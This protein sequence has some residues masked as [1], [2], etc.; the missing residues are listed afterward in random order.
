MTRRCRAEVE[1]GDLDGRIVV[2][3][4]ETGAIDLAHAVG[5]SDGFATE[6]LEAVEVAYPKNEEE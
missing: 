4:N 6:L 2:W 3:L 5:L 1:I